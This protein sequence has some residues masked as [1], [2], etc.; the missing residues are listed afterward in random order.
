MVHE[1]RSASPKAQDGQFLEC[2]RTIENDRK[3]LTPFSISKQHKTASTDTFIKEQLE[4]GFMFTYLQI[5]SVGHF[6]YVLPTTVE[7][8]SC[9]SELIVKNLSS[10]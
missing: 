1:I 7:L 3:V 10:S 8:L 2:W 9:L 4:Q 5:A 6:F